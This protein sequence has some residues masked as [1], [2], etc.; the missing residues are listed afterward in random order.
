MKMENA[1]QKGGESNEL[2]EANTERFGFR[3]SRDSERQRRQVGVASRLSSIPDHRIR[4]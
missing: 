4:V 3:D 2:H 1:E